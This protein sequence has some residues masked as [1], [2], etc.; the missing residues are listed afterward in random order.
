VTFPV[1]LTVSYK[2][3]ELCRTYNVAKV[4]LLG[5]LFLRL[6]TTFIMWYEQCHHSYFINMVCQL[7]YLFANAL[8]DKFLYLLP[9][10]DDTEYQ[11]PL[12][13]L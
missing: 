8:I 4:A 13:C 5:W 11:D 7:Q 9:V 1:S 3:K 2:I 10:F 12:T 6:E